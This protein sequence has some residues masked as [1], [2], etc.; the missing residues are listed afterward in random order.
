MKK[1]VAEKRFQFYN[2]PN[3]QLQ[4]LLIEDRA[5]YNIQRM[6]E[7]LKKSPFSTDEFVQAVLKL[8]LNNVVKFEKKGCI[9]KYIYTRNRNMTIDEQVDFANIVEDYD[10]KIS[11]SEKK[12]IE[13]IKYCVAEKSKTEHQDL[14]ARIIYAEMIADYVS[15]YHEEVE[16]KVKTK[17][18]LRNMLW[19]GQPFD[20]ARH[21]I[22][23]IAYH[24]AGTP[25]YFDE[26]GRFKDRYEWYFSTICNYERVIKYNETLKRD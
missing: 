11:I 2:A 24:I 25:I 4:L 5:V 21:L 6:V 23:H 7:E 20:S 10:E 12:L 13:E 22:D 3:I 17:C 15:T 8:V 16:R 1:Q 9:G 26:S 14:L 19:S 18:Y